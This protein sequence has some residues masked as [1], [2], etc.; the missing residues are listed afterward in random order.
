MHILQA[1]RFH[2]CAPA[3]EAPVDKIVAMSGLGDELMHGRLVAEPLG[4]RK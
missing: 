1:R 3:S 4:K 2:K